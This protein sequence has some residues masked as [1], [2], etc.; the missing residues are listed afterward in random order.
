MALKLKNFNL[1]ILCDRKAVNNCLHKVPYCLCAPEKMLGRIK[2]I[3]IQFE[4]N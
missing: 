1:A 2:S 3:I 4:V